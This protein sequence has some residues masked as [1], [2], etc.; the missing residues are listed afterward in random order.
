VSEE[1]ETTE[2]KRR[3]PT[4]AH[5]FE[6]ALAIGLIAFLRMLGVGAASALGGAF[7]GAIGPLIRPISKRG[8]ANLKMIFPDWDDRRVRR[9]IRGVWTNLGRTAAEFAHLD[10]FGVGGPEARIE[11]RGRERLARVVASGKSAIF[12]S[13]H[14]ANWETMTIAL[15][16]AGVPH[17]LVYRAANNPLI[18]KLIIRERAR[19][20]TQHQIVKG[21]RGA[22]A[23]VES[24]R[25]R[26]AIA[27]LV[28]QKLTDGV[29]APFMGRDAPT[30]A[31][32]ARLSLKFGAPIY[33][34][35]LERLSGARMR[36]TVHPPMEFKP[37]GD[38]DADVL[39]L[40]TL[41][42]AAI[43]KD[44]R[45]RPEQWLWLHRRWGKVLPAPVSSLQAGA[46][47][48]EPAAGDAPA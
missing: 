29:V 21:Q 8:E 6:F 1:T 23:L 13:G 20:M 32:A 17:A 5:R 43:E 33:Y 41:I 7:V 2:T 35:S 24:L 9:T 27:M 36:L 4:L 39:A 12:V 38:L 42:N 34:G 25:A 26:R 48:A 47:V 44:I 28:D 40:T 37:S 46:S 3:E 31:A 10:A 16:A 22:R 11:V 19:T 15:R 18:D 14:F 45:A 30:G